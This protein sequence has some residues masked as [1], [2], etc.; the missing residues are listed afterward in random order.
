L[1]AVVWSFSEVNTWRAR[2]LITQRHLANLGEAP[3][4]LACEAFVMY[5]FDVFLHQQQ[6]CD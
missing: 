4:L 5:M 2:W 6:H 1:K 3:P